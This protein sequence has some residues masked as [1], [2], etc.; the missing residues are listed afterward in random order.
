MIKVRNLEPDDKDEVYQHLVLLSQ[1]TESES[2]FVLTKNNFKKELEKDWYGI[3]A[4]DGN[5]I[6]GSCL[7]CFANINRAFKESQILFLDS[8]F[9]KK[10]HRKQKVATKLIEELV[11]IAKERNINRIQLWCLKSNIEGVSFYKQVAE[12]QNDLFDIYDIRV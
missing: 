11:K 2:H 9:V 3:V 1:H 12:R 6:V 10:G 7:Y 8:L 4:I 5:I